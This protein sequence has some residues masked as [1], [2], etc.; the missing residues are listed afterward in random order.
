M[1]RRENE[2]DKKA[3]SVGTHDNSRQACPMKY[4]RLGD[5]PFFY[6]YYKHI[7]PCGWVCKIICF[8]VFNL[9]F[10]SLT[11]SKYSIF[12]P[13]VYGYGLST[14]DPFTS[15]LPPSNYTLKALTE[16]LQVIP[17]DQNFPNS[18]KILILK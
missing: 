13:S 4:Q 8:A 14:H 12:C 17:Q 2:R 15:A 1:K 6:S 3:A 5:Q 11:S 9:L 18:V 10:P 16:K 7:Y